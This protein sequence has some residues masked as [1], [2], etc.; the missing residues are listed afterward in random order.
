[1]KYL[2]IY[3]KKTKDYTAYDMYNWYC[4]KMV[5]EHPELYFLESDRIIRDRGVR[6]LM[7]KSRDKATIHMTYTMFRA[8]VERINEKAKELIIS[9]E[10]YKIS[11]RLGILLGRRIERNFSKPQVNVIAT[12]ISRKFNPNAPTVYLTDDDYCRVAWKKQSKVHGGG[13]RNQQYYEFR[14]CKNFRK[15]FSRAQKKDPLLKYKYEF[16]ANK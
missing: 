9:G 2:S 4:N 15:E 3:K 16:K 10:I 11:N 5:A 1:M 8:I 7:K 6:V 14:P 12:V 13:V